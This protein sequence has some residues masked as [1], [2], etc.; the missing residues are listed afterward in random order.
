LDDVQ[1]AG[2]G[3]VVSFQCC[4]VDGLRMVV[5]AVRLPFFF[6][7]NRLASEKGG[8]SRV[9]FSR[10]AKVG[11]AG[12]VFSFFLSKKKLF[13]V[14]LESYLKSLAFCTVTLYSHFV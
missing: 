6:S 12:L 10:L 13:R 4:Q 9:P 1:L 3:A 14:F 8:V 2:A 7:S 5:V 11:F